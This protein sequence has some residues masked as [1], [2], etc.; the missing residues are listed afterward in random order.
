[1]YKVVLSAVCTIVFLV[2]CKFAYPPVVINNSPTTRLFYITHSCGKFNNISKVKLEPYQVLWV[3]EGG[4]NPVLIQNIV[5]KT[6]DGK[7]IN[8]YDS[9]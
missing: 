1:M 6:I 8:E 2:G 3:G 4:P 5:V 9:N 7:K